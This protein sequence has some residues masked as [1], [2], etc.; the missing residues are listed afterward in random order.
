[1]TQYLVMA[2]YNMDDLPI[3]LF[4]NRKAAV[5]YA[6]TVSEDQIQDVADRLEVDGLALP[7]MPSRLGELVSIAIVEFEDTVTLLRETIDTFEE[8]LLVFKFARF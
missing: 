4:D 8:V 6:T 3:G 7:G 1:M 2:R 5:D